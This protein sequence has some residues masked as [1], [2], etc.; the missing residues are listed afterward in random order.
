MENSLKIQFIGTGCPVVLIQDTTNYLYGAS[1]YYRVL[2]ITSSIIGG[3]IYLDTDTDG[4]NYPINTHDLGFEDIDTNGVYLFA[5]PSYAE[6]PGY[7]FPEGAII[8][9]SV[10]N[11]PTGL[12]VGFYIANAG[13]DYDTSE[14]WT[15]IDLSTIPDDDLLKH[16]LDQD[17]V[18]YG[19]TPIFPLWDKE[20]LVRSCVAPTTKPD[21]TNVLSGATIN[22]NTDGYYTF[23]WQ[24]VEGCL[25]DLYI[26][27]YDGTFTTPFAENIS[28]NSFS[29][30][31]IPGIRYKIYVKAINVYG[32]INGTEIDFY[33]F[34]AFVLMPDYLYPLIDIDVSNPTF[35]WVNN[36]E[37]NVLLNNAIEIIRK[38]D[39]EESYLHFYSSLNAGSGISFACPVELTPGD[40]RWRI[41]PITGA[42]V[43]F[44]DN[45]GAFS[46]T[47]SYEYLGKVTVTSPAAGSSQHSSKEYDLFVSWDALVGAARYMIRIYKA[48]ETDPILEIFTT[49]TELTVYLNDYGSYAVEITPIDA[50][51]I[52][53]NQAP[54]R[55]AFTL[56]KYPMPVP[57]I[58]TYPTTSGGVVGLS[59][60]L[61]FEVQNNT[62]VLRIAIYESRSNNKVYDKTEIVASG[63]AIVIAVDEFGEYN[64]TYK[65]IFEY[66][67]GPNTDKIVSIPFY[68]YVNPEGALIEP[69]VSVNGTELTGIV[70]N[71]ESIAH[72]SWESVEGASGYYLY[73]YQVGKRKEKIELLSP[74]ALS[75]DTRLTPGVAYK[76][77]V[78]PYSDFGKEPD[79]ITYYTLSTNIETNEASMEYAIVKLGCYQYKIVY[80]GVGN[81]DNLPYRIKSYGGDLILEGTFEPGETEVII[82]LPIMPA[83]G[84][85]IAE[86]GQLYEQCIPIYEF[87]HIKACIDKMINYILC[88]EGCIDTSTDQVTCDYLSTLNQ[89]IL[90]YNLTKLL[91]LYN[92]LLLTINM[93]RVFYLYIETADATHLG[94]INKVQRIMEALE[95]L[96][97]NCGFCD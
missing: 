66:Q 6:N 74:L 95:Q 32:E 86:I 37:T 80:F 60:D 53:S 72:I 39:G 49:E 73:L 36:T 17:L 84:V 40:Y 89:D 42:G 91:G 19:E 12:G 3:V 87:C 50:S 23:N 76:L 90:R 51:G 11:S 85:Y 38:E 93:E 8:Y 31:L 63:D 88:N 83:N 78:V 45:W 77:A 62:S 29:I 15:L 67:Y 41:M 4:S 59:E 13:A 92:E 24:A 10:D 48:I 14:D 33:V 97:L 5:I 94:Y 46:V 43:H 9:S 70:N 54:D 7:S 18:V 55:I 30:S 79:N 21:I 44:N 26:E 81:I 35:R 57:V 58:W 75:Y 47:S 34:G 71:V 22:L 52:A 2:F 69:D 1:S 25:Y 16:F 64:K 27:Q 56:L 68:F 28:T 96:S 20:N 61:E 82:D 65:L